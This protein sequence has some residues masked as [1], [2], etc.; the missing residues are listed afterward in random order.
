MGEHFY[1]PELFVWD[2]EKGQILAKIFGE[3]NETKQD[4]SAASVAQMFG[5]MPQP[6]SRLA[7]AGGDE[8]VLF[9]KD[10]RTVV[11]SLAKQKAL[12]RRGNAQYPVASVTRSIIAYRE[13]RSI[14]VW[15]L[16]KQQ[17]VA[18]LPE[19]VKQLKSRLTTDDFSVRPLA[20]LQDGDLLVTL[21]CAGKIA[22]E[23]TFWPAASW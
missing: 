16:E 6:A 9:Y 18:R 8:H 12:L 22:R 17:Q 4:I 1:L 5:R 3:H 11:W 23:L 20:L 14:V 19:D 21:T 7:F 10:G 2:L 13:T 15:D